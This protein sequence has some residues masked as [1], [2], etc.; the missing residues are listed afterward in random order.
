[1][2]KSYKLQFRDNY[3]SLLEKRKQPEQPGAGLYYSL[4]LGV[5]GILN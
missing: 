4:G 2:S 1:M 3:S 5:T